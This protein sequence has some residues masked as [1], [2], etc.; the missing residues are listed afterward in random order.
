[1]RGLIAYPYRNCI[2]RRASKSKRRLT[3]AQCLT[4]PLLPLALHAHTCWSLQWHADIALSGHRATSKSCNIYIITLQQGQATMCHDDRERRFLLQPKK[5][6]ISQCG[7]FFIYFKN[8]EKLGLLIQNLCD[9]KIPTDTLCNFLHNLVS[10]STKQPHLPNN[11]NWKQK[12][13]GTKLL[14]F[15]LNTSR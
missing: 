3:W 7:I 13:N 8:L 1:M 15:I 5:Q 2:N 4:L 10:F 14:H 11:K 9:A 6:L 12:P